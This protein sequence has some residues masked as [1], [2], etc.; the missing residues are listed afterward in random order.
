MYFQPKTTAGQRFNYRLFFY[1]WAKIIMFIGLAMIAPAVVSFLYGEAN[2]YGFVFGIFI[3]FLA[4]TTLA[5]Y[6]KDYCPLISKKDGRLIVGLLWI[7]IP[8]L[9]AIPFILDS[10]NFTLTDAIFESFSGFTTTGFSIIKSSYAQIDKGILLWRALTQ[11]I[12]SLG[13]VLFVIVFLNSFRDGSNNLFDARFNSINSEKVHP[14]IRAT[15]YRI[16]LTYITLSLISCALLFLCKMDIFNALCY[17]F[18]TVST[19]GFSYTDGGVGAF[20]LHI[21]Y[22]I[23]LTMFL[24][25]ISYYLLY[26]LPNVR[27]KSILKDEQFRIYSLLILIC[28]LILAI[29]FFA[30]DNGLESSVHTAL[31]SVVSAVS[32]TGYN[33]SETAN[34]NFGSLFVS[35]FILLL[36]FPGGCSASSST[37]LKIIRISILVKYIKVAGKR[38]LHS[39]AILPV[40]FNKEIVKDEDVNRIFGFFFLYIM[41]FICGTVLLTCCGTNFSDSLAL[42]ASSLSNVGELAKS[43]SNNVSFIAL[44]AKIKIILIILMTLGRIE[45]YSFFALFSHSL[46]RKS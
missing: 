16:F 30:N 35:L 22:V 14:H 18:S 20:S 46:W 26:R 13:F 3:C 38:I 17:G 23:L 25:G 27:K 1:I 40:R 8:I 37:G 28:S 4:G 42:S 12:G 41:I 39:N 5:Y 2:A 19:G 15:V 11:W 32:T 24:S 43:V 31:F 9:G 45:I 7:T 36:M 10:E 29:Y 34:V 33:L 6:N 21:Q 44:D